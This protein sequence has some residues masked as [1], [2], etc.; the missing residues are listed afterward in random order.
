VAIKFNQNAVV[1]DGEK[2]MRIAILSSADVVTHILLHPAFTANLARPGSTSGA[3][4]IPT[5]YLMRQ[6]IMHAIN[7]HLIA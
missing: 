4:T 2:K 7:V 3:I 6:M 5:S 1:S